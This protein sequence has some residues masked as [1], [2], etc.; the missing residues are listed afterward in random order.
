[1]ACL[2][3]RPGI[4]IGCVFPATLLLLP[5]LA[6]RDSLSW[7]P[8]SLGNAGMLW[9]NLHFQRRKATSG[10]EARIDAA[11]FCAVLNA[12]LPRG[13]HFPG[14]LVG[15]AMANS[16]EGKK[17]DFQKEFPQGGFGHGLA[18]PR[19]FY[20]CLGWAAG[21]GRGCFECRA[22]RAHRSAHPFS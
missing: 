10:A 14:P 19:L 8:E 4:P 5:C 20:P 16:C 22:R 13:S 9:K 2:E 15:D 3:A 21:R 6:G 7:L 17:D 12:P 11:R 1:M 18:V